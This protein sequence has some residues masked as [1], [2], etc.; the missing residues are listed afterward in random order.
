MEGLVAGLGFEHKRHLSLLDGLRDG[1]NHT[2]TIKGHRCG[3]VGY[4]DGFQAIPPV[5]VVVGQC[6]SPMYVCFGV[7]THPHAIVQHARSRYAVDVGLGEFVGVFD[8]VCDAELECG[9]DVLEL[10]PHLAHTLGIL[11]GVAQ[12]TSHHKV[13]LVG[14][15][16]VVEHQLGRIAHRLNILRWQTVGVVATVGVV[17][18]KSPKLVVHKSIP[19]PAGLLVG[20][21]VVL[22]GIAID[23]LIG[24]CC[25]LGISEACHIVE[26]FGVV[27]EDVCPRF[28]SAKH[29]NL[30]AI[31]VALCD[32][33]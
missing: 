14:L 20:A 10:Q 16:V 19:R 17:G 31:E 25:P 23:P 1:K 26:R 2:L 13:K 24:V 29:G 4:A 5:I 32:C 3:G 9:E 15:G 30:V 7:A 21:A 28:I 27:L 12:G 22:R 6:G 18:D 11:G 8:L 33:G